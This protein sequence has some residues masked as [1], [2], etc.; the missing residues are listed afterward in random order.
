MTIKA[1]AITLMLVQA[2]RLF[3]QILKNGVVQEQAEAPVVN[4]EY[5]RL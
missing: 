4:K 5:P 2:T 3:V 1:S